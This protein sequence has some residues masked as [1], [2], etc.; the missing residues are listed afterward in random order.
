VQERPI[1][2]FLFNFISVPIFRIDEVKVSVSL[3]QSGFSTD[4]RFPRFFRHSVSLRIY[5]GNRTQ[6]EYAFLA[7]APIALLSGTTSKTPKLPQWSTQHTVPHERPRDTLQERRSNH[8]QGSGYVII[9]ATR[10]AL[11]ALWP[12]F[13]VKKFVVQNRIDYQ[14][15]SNEPNAKRDDCW[16][17][18][19]SFIYFNC[20]C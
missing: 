5:K 14:A 20:I 13:F 3:I 8:A 2:R 15:N 19:S 12:S 11:A 1:G 16:L 6:S 17:F 10:M 4:C 18:D 7:K 9:P